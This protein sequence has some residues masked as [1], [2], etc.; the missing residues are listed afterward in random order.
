MY[1]K[2]V[3]KTTRN[4][5]VF[6]VTGKNPTK[7]FSTDGYDIFLLVLCAIFS[8]VLEIQNFSR[9]YLYYLAL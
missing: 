3:K 2:R 5:E 7:V 8:I 6:T 4:V 9:A 1:W